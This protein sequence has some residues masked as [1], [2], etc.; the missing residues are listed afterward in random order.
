MTNDPWHDLPR[1][2]WILGLIVGNSVGKKLRK[3]NKGLRS[4]RNP[5]F[6]LAGW[7]GLEPSASGVTGRFAAIH[8]NSDKL[9]LLM[10]SA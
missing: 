2:T 4:S 1:L 9:I 10:I 6:L 3:K 8:A 5:L 7:K